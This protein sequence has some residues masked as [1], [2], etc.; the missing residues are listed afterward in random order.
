MTEVISWTKQARFSAAE[1][2]CEN[3]AYQ[4]NYISGRNA[5]EISLQ[6]VVGAGKRGRIDLHCGAV[7]F[8]KIRCHN[9]SCIY[10]YICIEICVR[11]PSYYR[12]T[13]CSHCLRRDSLHRLLRPCASALI[14][15]ISDFCFCSQRPCP[16]EDLV[17][18][19]QPRLARDQCQYQHYVLITLL[20]P[21]QLVCLGSCKILA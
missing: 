20:L 13:H 10:I 19:P 14:T 9:I 3:G 12:S 15:Y 6:G 2:T 8:G 1:V 16:C 5:T 11:A 18:P 4:S 17:R 21:T 7:V